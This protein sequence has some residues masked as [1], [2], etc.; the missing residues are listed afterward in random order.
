MVGTQ[1]KK[2]STTAL[3]RK[4]DITSKEMFVRLVNLGLIEKKGDI[5]SLTNEGVDKGGK[6]IS[7]KRSGS[8][9]RG[10]RI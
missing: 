7:S 1:V 8:I 10:L 6:F 9:L 4:Y 5:W 2:I 3:A